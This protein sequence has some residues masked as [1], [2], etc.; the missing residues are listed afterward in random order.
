V[1]RD[2]FEIREIAGIGEGVNPDDGVARVMLDPVMHE[3]RSDESGGPGY[4]E[5]T[6][7]RKS[8]KS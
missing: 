1:I 8:M 7:C 4:E 5:S 2:G 3:V 6:H